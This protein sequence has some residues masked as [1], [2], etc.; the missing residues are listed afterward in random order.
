[1]TKI[2]RTIL[3]LSLL[4]ITG[5][6]SRPQNPI[7]IAINPWPGYEFLYLA[8]QR[9]YFEKVGLNIKLVQFTS[10]GD[11]QT[12]YINGRV[13]GLAST[14]VELVQAHLLSDR[15]LETILV[16]DYSNGGDVLI[17]RNT[18]NSVSE[19]QGHSVGAEITSLGIYFLQQALQAA[20]L[21]LDD[22]NAINVD[23]LD[24][25][26]ALISGQIDAFVTYPPTSINIL[27]HPEFHT[28]FSSAEIPGEIIDVI[29]IDKSLL[30]QQPEL[31]TK[32][33]RAWQMALDYH[34]THPLEAV[35]IMAT[36]ER[37]SAQDFQNVLLDLDVLSAGEQTPFFMEPEKFIARTRAVCQA[38]KSANVH[39]RSCDS[40]PGIAHAQF[41]ETAI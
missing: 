9:G 7:T 31:V 14:L 37:I 25:E 26:Q 23:Q 11:S 13:D 16:A 8:E 29:S 15:P 21:G 39:T 40:T 5:S 19:L 32:L 27:K 22:V 6:C 10:L 12:A 20:A 41:D 3:L 38:L 36:R 28:I 35:A 33:H 30:K 4:S 34:R 2:C 18:I 24:G 17:A 1:M